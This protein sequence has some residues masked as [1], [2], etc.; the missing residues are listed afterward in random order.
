MSFLIRLG[1]YNHDVRPLPRSPLGAPSTGP[2]PKAPYPPSCK[3]PPLPLCACHAPLPLRMTETSL[4]FL[5]AAAAKTATGV[6]PS[7]MDLTGPTPSTKRAPL[8]KEIMVKHDITYKD[9][10]MVFLYLLLPFTILL[11]TW[12]GMSR[13]GCPDFSLFLGHTRD[14]RG[15][16]VGTRVGTRGT[17]PQNGVPEALKNEDTGHKNPRLR[18]TSQNM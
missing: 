15:T 10:A 2:P 12:L 9:M 1:T 7:D 4:H 16:R 18:D 6:L 11:R 13:I 14:T 5:H 3:P 8:D 17:C